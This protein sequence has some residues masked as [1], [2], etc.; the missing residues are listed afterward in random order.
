MDYDMHS[1]KGKITFLNTGVAE[2]LVMKRKYSVDVDREVNVGLGYSYQLKKF[3]TF[4]GTPKR[5]I[6]LNDIEYILDE[7]D[8]R[9]YLEIHFQNPSNYGGEMECIKHVSR[10]KEVK[11]FFT[12]DAAEVEA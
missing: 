8:L 2:S 10:G 1:G 7:E 5:T 11:A 9:D 3:L 12:E 6:L 4:C